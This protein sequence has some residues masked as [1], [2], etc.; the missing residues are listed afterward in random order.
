MKNYL[1]YLYHMRDAALELEVLTREV[2]RESVIKQ[3][4]ERNIEIIGAAAK[5]IPGDL[6]L[7]WSAVPWKDIIDMRN[8][9]AHEYIK[10]T[11]GYLRTIIAAD[12]PPLLDAIRNIIAQHGE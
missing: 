11:M 4:M 7:Q 5:R 12:I 9:I 2:G 3:A 8:I 6:Q 1:V 10:I